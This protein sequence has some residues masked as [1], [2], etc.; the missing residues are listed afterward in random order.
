MF[1]S[2][3]SRRAFLRRVFS[4][5]VISAVA[6]SV[7]LGRLT[8]LF[9]ASDRGEVLGGYPIHLSD[10][11]DLATVGGSVKLV[12]DEQLLL[13][14]DHLEWKDDGLRAETNAFSCKRGWYPIA[15]TRVKE[16]GAD[17]FTAVSTLCPHE[18]EY[19]VAF[20]PLRFQF[21]CCHQSSSFRP[22]GTWISPSDPD[23]A[24]PN[25]PSSGSVTRGLRKFPTSFDDAN[26][27]TLEIPTFGSDD[28]VHN[29]QRSLVLE[30]NR[31]NPANR[32][33][34]ISFYLPS[35]SPVELVVMASDGKEVVRPV[36]RTLAEGAHSIVVSTEGLPSGLYLYRIRTRFGSL[37]RRMVVQ[38]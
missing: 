14:P 37:D 31:P 7:T 5:T 20:D 13:N 10:Y 27:V 8:P 29:V 26:T 36:D 33:T 15:V 32:S 28:E 1:D 30:P 12:R 19:Q 23:A 6:P 3:D 24:D 35:S 25:A 9:H 11:P 16:S 17:A 21:V 4:L 18:A 34:E 38:H 2:S 22:D